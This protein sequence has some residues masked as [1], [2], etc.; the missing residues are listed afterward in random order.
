MADEEEIRRR[1]RDISLSNICGKYEG[2]ACN[3]SGCS[4]SKILTRFVG[5]SRS[6]D[7]FRILPRSAIVSTK[8]EEEYRISLPVGYATFDTSIIEFTRACNSTNFSIIL[9]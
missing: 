4:G 7:L 8:Q 2:D 5:S 1:R 9:S 6:C 3:R